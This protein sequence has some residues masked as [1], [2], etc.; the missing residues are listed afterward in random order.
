M[1][2]LGPGIEWGPWCGENFA[3]LLECEPSGDQGS[4]PPCRLH[5][6]C[7]GSQAGGQPIATWKIARP[8][9]PAQRHLRYQHTVRKDGFPELCMLRRIDVVVPS[10]EHRD[11][12][13][14]EACA[15]GSRVNAAG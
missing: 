13:R 15:M 1:A 10:R 14:N 6:Q 8:G 2:A 12:S 5:D 3:A 7:S 4:R 11:G 9:L